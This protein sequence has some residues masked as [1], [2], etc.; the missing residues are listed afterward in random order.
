[1]PSSKN[2]FKKDTALKGR[3]TG[4]RATKVDAN[5]DGKNSA[6]RKAHMKTSKKMKGC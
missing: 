2:P 5:Y 1:M 3:V 6:S 4:S